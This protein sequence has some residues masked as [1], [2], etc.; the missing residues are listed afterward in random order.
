MLLFRH[1]EV[2]RMDFKP[3]VEKQRE[4]F[5]TGATKNV[6]FRLAALEKL[7]EAIVSHEG[8]IEKA[9]R[10][11]LGKAPFETYI[12]EIGLVLSEIDYFIVHLRKLARPKKVRTPIVLFKAKS[13]IMPEPFGT[14]LIMSPWNYPL[15]LALTPLAGALAAGNTAVV[16]PGSYA[17]ETCKMIKTI[18]EESFKPEYVAVVLGGREENQ[19]LLETRFDYI[20]FT[21]STNIGKMVMEKASRYLTPVSL[22]LGGKSPCLIDSGVNMDLVAK[23]LAFGKFINAGQ[24]C[25]APDYVLIRKEDENDLVEGLKKYIRLFFGSD[26]L[27][28]EELPKIINQKHYERLLGLINPKKIVLGGE[29]ANEKIAPT[30]MTGVTWE[31]DIMKEEIFGPVLPIITYDSLDQAYDMIIDHEKPLAFYLFTNDR[32]V[33]KEALDRISFGGATI[34]DTLMHFG[35]T[36]L[37]F[38][39]VGASGM[40]RYHGKFSFETF[41]NMRSVL[42]RSNLVDLEM[43]YHPYSEAKGNIA[44]KLLK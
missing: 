10:N 29:H 36:E 42:E 5:R 32:K 9:L 16:K 4:F 44:R 8:E 22:E 17:V 34:N 43:R 27:L 31:D 33:R 12:T 13:Y 38:G 7:K 20:F 25:V 11:D 14:V 35:S 41:S 6:E 19:Q 1:M 21:G 28:C 40:G 15:Q 39:G 24:T 2:Y 37:G 3:L 23:R 26:P 18:I 30:V